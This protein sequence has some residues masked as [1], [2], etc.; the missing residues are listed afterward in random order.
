[1]FWAAHSLI[2]KHLT[3]TEQAGTLTIWLL[4]L[5]TPINAALALGAGPDAGFSLPSGAL[6]AVVAAGLLTAVAQHLLVRAYMQADAAFLQ[7]FDHLKLP[8]N[9]L[10][11]YLAFGF[12]PAGSMWLGSAVIV[13]AS[14]YLLRDEARASQPA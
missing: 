14:F 7:P 9:V 2:T 11:G 6:W 5:L 10:L 8:L 4:L 1:V 13:G 3:V 12:L